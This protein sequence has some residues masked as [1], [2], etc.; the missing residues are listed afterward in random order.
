MLQ[1]ILATNV[2]IFRKIQTRIQ[3]QLRKCQNYCATEDNSFYWW[4]GSDTY[5]IRRI[6]LT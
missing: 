1:H 4:N 3:L 5:L 2:T 6:E